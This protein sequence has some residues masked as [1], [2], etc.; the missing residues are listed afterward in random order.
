[1]T[2]QDIFSNKQEIK[3]KPKIIIDFREKNSLVVSELM[4][5]G[6]EINFQQLKLGDYIVKNV[7]IERKTISDFTSSMINKRLISQLNDLKELKSKILIIEGTEEQDLYTSSGINENA[8]RGFILSISLN[9]Q[10]PIILTQDYEDTAKFILVLAKKQ[11]KEKEVSLN[12][13]RKPFDKKE[14]LQFILEGF[15][16][17]GPKNAKKL[18]EEKKNLKNIFNSS[19]EELEKI[20]GKKAEI[21]KLINQNYD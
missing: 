21:F 4:H 7:V 9:Y 19:F 8:I 20:I 12:F 2:F 18:L 3:I 10:I 1:M 13:N 6:C 11:E 16:G 15:P 5:L 17:I 14:Q